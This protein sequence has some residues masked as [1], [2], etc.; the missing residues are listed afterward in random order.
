MT[1]KTCIHCESEFNQN[2]REKRAA[3]GKVDECPSCVNELQTEHAIPYL[4]V[5]MGEG[6]QGGI[7]ILAFDD[8]ASRDAYRKSW[9]NNSGHNKGKSCQ[10]GKHTSSMTGMNVRK[11]GETPANS[12]HKGR[13]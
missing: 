1:Y 10:L 5:A 8:N 2:S 7:Q 9:R 12:N 11:I 13:M 3:G 6:K 4:G